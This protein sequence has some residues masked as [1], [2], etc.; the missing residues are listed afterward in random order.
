MPE[1]AGQNKPSA[2]T[3]EP[4]APQNLTRAQNVILTLKVIAG[5]CLIIAALWVIDQ[6]KR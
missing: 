5:A 2:D 6:L 3:P 4:G 1:Q